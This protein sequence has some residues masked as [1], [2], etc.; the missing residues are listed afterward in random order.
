MLRV[1]PRS[2]WR[3]TT[4]N[5]GAGTVNMSTS[6]RERTPRPQVEISC[7]ETG[8]PHG[9]QSARWSPR[10]APAGAAQVTPAAGPHR[11]GVTRVVRMTDAL[12]SSAYSQALEVI[13]SVEPRI[14]DG[15][16]AGARRPAGLAQA[17]RQ[18]EL[19][20]A[21]GAAHHGH[22]VQRQVRRGHGRPPLLRRLPERRHR[23]GA[24]RRAR[25]RAVRR[26][27][28]LRAAALRHR[29]QPGRVLVDPRPPGRGPRRWRSSAPKN[30]NELTDADWET[31]RHELGNQRLLGMSLDA[32]GHLTHG[33]RPNIS[34]KMFHQQQ[35]GTDPETGLLD[36]DEV[37]GQGPRSSSRWCSSPATRRTRAG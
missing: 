20:L 22:L 14:A 33:F 28:R 37:R 7:S 8:R 12:I 35:Y 27:V 5:R 26:A 11:R 9:G 32:G 34:G 23:R 29:R 24:R 4:R 30:V 2:T 25:A 6:L 15:H 36:Y 21:R 13:A 10:R 16:P 31:L 17:D 1:R 3:R 19:R 18:R